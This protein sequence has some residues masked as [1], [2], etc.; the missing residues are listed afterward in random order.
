MAP[1]YSPL[2][3]V[4]ACFYGLLSSDQAL[5][6]LLAGGVR[7]DVPESPQF[8]FLWIEVLESQQFGGLGTKPGV[9]ALPEVEI[10]LHVFSAYAG[11]TNAHAAIARAI[12]LVSATDVLVVNGYK[13][14]GQEP[15]HDATL[16]LHD[17]ELNGV[18]CRELVSMHR[19]YVEE[20]P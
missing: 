11:A 7:T 2:G 1:T 8:D 4:S 20:L 3:P 13:V 10:R 5:N 16:P 19:L 6:T 15:F 18:K 14:A 9:G 12:A 17:Q